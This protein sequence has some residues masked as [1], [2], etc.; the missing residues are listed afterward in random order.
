MTYEDI[1]TRHF[2]FLMNSTSAVSWCKHFFLLSSPETVYRGLT[3]AQESRQPPFDVYQAPKS[4]PLLPK[5]G[6]FLRIP[7]DHPGGRTDLPI[8][9]VFF[10]Y[11]HQIC[12]THSCKAAN[13]YCSQG[14]STDQ[15]A[16]CV[17]VKKLFSPTYAVTEHQPVHLFET[18]DEHCHS[19]YDAIV[20]RSMDQSILQQGAQFLPSERQQHSPQ[21]IILLPQ[22]I[23]LQRENSPPVQNFDQAHHL[24]QP[25]PLRSNKEG[26][27]FLF[28]QQE[29][30]R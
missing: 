17:L 22:Q 10:N 23:N 15:T 3:M 6:Y 9:P 7:L 21:Q 11:G 24:Q 30:K 1:Y 13:Q 26:L 18:D 8:F 20:Q 29:P 5:P 14:L 2:T 28:T 19:S 25:K 4:R 12:P 27:S 16:A